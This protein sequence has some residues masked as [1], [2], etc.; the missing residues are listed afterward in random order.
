MNQLTEWNQ[1]YG[2][3]D[4]SLLQQI[5]Y[6]ID[7]VVDPCVA[8]W[9]V[10]AQ[11]AAEPFGDLALDLVTPDPLD[12]AKDARAPRTVGG[13]RKRS[14]RGRRRLRLPGMPDMDELGAEFSKS[15]RTGK[16]LARGTRAAAFNAPVEKIE[17][18]VWQ[19]MLFSMVTEALYET[20]FAMQNS[21]WCSA[22]TYGRA[23]VD[24]IN[25]SQV[26]PAGGTGVPL[27]GDVSVTAPGQAGLGFVGNNNWP[28]KGVANGRVYHAADNPQEMSVWATIND[29][30]G[31]KE[32]GRETA[33]LQPGQTMDF[34]FNGSASSPGNFILNWSSQGN[35]P[36]VAD[37]TV[38]ALGVNGTGSTS[39]VYPDAPEPF[40][41]DDPDAS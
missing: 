37:A 9:Y 22:S 23:R 1:F 39:P 33:T 10:Y 14:G 8:P 25:W 17:K 24:N 32:V 13:C 6:L 18:R 3:P 29:K 16:L 11:F 26:F 15:K 34:A 7:F 12:V 20:A 28:F 27:Q 40:G 41:P 35:Y 31:E 2:N 36:R 4:P 38:F 30:D 21:A 5:N 19:F